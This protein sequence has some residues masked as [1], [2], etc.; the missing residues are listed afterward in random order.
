MSKD[1]ILPMDSS[2]YNFSINT[3]S[4]N[5]QKKILTTVLKQTSIKLNNNLTDLGSNTN[6][7]NVMTFFGNMLNTYTI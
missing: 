7:Y 4:L 3:P 5:L 6:T 2:F 1:E